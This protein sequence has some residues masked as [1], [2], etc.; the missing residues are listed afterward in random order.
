MTAREHAL[1]LARLLD[2]HKAE[3]VVVLEVAGHTIMTDYFVLATAR[4][5]THMA[6]LADAVEAGDPLLHHREGRDTSLWLLLD[7]GDVVVHLFTAE[8]RA[9]YG[10]E[11]LWGD[12]PKLDATAAT[13]SL[14]D[15]E[16]D[17]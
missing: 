17:V 7:C 2:R 4:N 12:V 10:L 16:Q 8:G 15:G 1:T 9:F 3:E 14:T 13:M 5:R 11:R 6:A